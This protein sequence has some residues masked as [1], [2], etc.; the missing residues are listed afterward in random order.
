M[1]TNKWMMRKEKATG[2]YSDGKQK[3]YRIASTL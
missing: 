1:L 3:K 2:K